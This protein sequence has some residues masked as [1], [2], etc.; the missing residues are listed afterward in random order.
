[1]FCVSDLKNFEVLLSMKIPKTYRII[2]YALLASIALGWLCEYFYQKSPQRAIPIEKFSAELA[3][4]E[5]LATE[6]LNDLKDIIVRSSADSL[7]NYRYADNDISYYLFGKGELVFWSDNHIEVQDNPLNETN[8]W[9]YNKLSNAHCLVK[10]VPVDSGR[11]V[12]VIVV[13]YNYPYENRD[14]INSFA[15]D[16]KIDKRIELVQGS[17][18]DKYAVFDAQNHYL[19]SL[20]RPEVPIYSDFWGISGLILNIISILLL[21]FLYANSDKL[22]NIKQFCVY[23]FGLITIC[24][25]II[26]GV[27]LYFNQP[28]LLYWNKVFSSFEYSSNPFLA[29]ISHLTIVTIYF[30]AANYLFFFHVNVGYRNR[31][32]KGFILQFLFVVYFLLVYYILSSLIFHS[33]IRVPILQFKDISFLGIWLHLLIFMWGVGLILLFYKTHNLLKAGHFFRQSVLFDLIL[34]LLAGIMLYLFSENEMPQIS[35]SLLVI[36]MVFYSPNILKKRKNI[37]SYLFVWV[38]IFTAFF[39][40]NSLLINEE[41]NRNKYRILAE[42]IY[43]NGNTENDRM[44]DILLEELDMQIIND[45]KIKQLSTYSDSTSKVNEYLNESYLR[46]FWNK[47][48]MRLYVTF[49][50]SAV[51]QQ[52]T[53]FIER[54]GTKLKNTHFYS[55]PASFSSMSYIG[56]FPVKSIENDSLFLFM[57][58]YPRKNFKSYSFPNLLISSTPDI[59]SQLKIAVAKYDNNLLTYSSGKT[60]FP[61]KSNWIPER[62]GDYYTITYQNKNYYVY[63]HDKNNKIVIT[64]LET[65]A[66]GNYLLYFAYTFLIFYTL[67]RIIIWLYTLKRRKTQFHIGFTSKFQNAF[68]ILLVISFLGIF[69]VSVNFI[70]QKY[71]D[72]QIQQIENKK[73]YIQ[74]ALQ[75]MY[76]WSQDLST[77]SRQGLNF[78]LQELSYMYQTDIHVYDNHGLLIGSSQ[79]LI[80]NKNLISRRISPE[81]FFTNNKNINQNEHIGKLNY[82]SGYTDFYNGD[83]LQIGYIAVPQ[84]LSRE[85]I[86]GEIEGFLSVIIHIYLIIIVLAI[87]LSLFIGRQLSA[88]L[89]MIE[90]KLKL[91][92]FG[93]RNEKIDYQL[94]DEIGQLV[95]QYNRTIDELEKSA[96]MLAQ[97]ERELAWKTMA[98]QI[99]HEINNPLTPM[100]LT[101]QQLQRRK[102]MDDESFDEYFEKSTLTLIEQIDNLSRIAGTFSNFARMPEAQFTRVD[103]AAKLYSVFQLFVNNHEQIK[104]NYEGDANGIFVLADPEQLVQVFNNLLKNAIQAIPS[105]KAG[106]IRVKIDCVGEDVKIEIADNGIGIPED[107]ADKLFVPNFTTKNTGMGLGLTI[108]KNIIE[109]TGGK[110]SFTTRVNK[111]TSFFIILPKEG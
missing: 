43:I 18:E 92:R 56:V 45:K 101:I 111:G 83:Y 110:I 105:E 68:I 58:F 10:S 4:K 57:E 67:S 108:S 86:R 14:L 53:S 2:I 12:A 96:K 29:S 48:D 62:K 32:L 25:G 103:V 30:L 64:E 26:I 39:I 1:M 33:S 74:K 40:V 44:A 51:Y 16:L 6:T 42:N 22:F 91:M 107:V 109:I 65:H 3:K 5:K 78:D 88:P 36:M 100:K 85:E 52:Y 60:D 7:I 70:Q 24:I 35:I 72:E 98:R 50:N 66:T 49:S 76:Y 8:I 31:R 21:L 81:P 97:S 20:A 73:S 99:A 94:N 80:F 93:H 75:D 19:F 15:Q 102:K 95:A 84:F 104:I 63:N 46:G 9:Q 37:Y 87:I 69:Y 13:K 55:V 90:N 23:K 79:P 28:S 47:Y 38:F 11:L 82:L 54:A 71:E 77:V 106:L 41:K 59:Q 27:S 17:D 34:V 61:N 89:K